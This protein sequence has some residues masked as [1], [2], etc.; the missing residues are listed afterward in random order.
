M[1]KSTFLNNGILNLIFQGTTITGIAQNA[2]TS[3]LT[4]LYVAL[5]TANPGVGGSQTTSE[6]AYT[7]YARVAV[8]RSSSGWSTSSASTVSP[9]SNITFPAATGGS[10]TESYFSIGTAATGAGNTLYAGTVTPNIS[11]SNGVQPYLNTSTAI[12]EA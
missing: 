2:T 12:S 7:G 8:A 6:A 10:E 11:I 1:P 4:S 3:P 9:V 5:H